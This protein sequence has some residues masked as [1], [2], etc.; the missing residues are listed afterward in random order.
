MLELYQR[1]LHANISFHG[2]LSFLNHWDFFVADPSNQFEQLISTGPH[3][4][5]LEAFAT[6]VKIRTR[7][8]HLLSSA[9]PQSMTTF[10]ASESRRVID[11]ARHF[12]VGFWGLDWQEQSTLEIIPQSIDVGADT[13]TPG[14][15]CLKYGNDGDGLGREYGVKQLQA[16][17]A[18]YLPAIT[19]RL[20][21][22]NPDF[23]LRDSE[24][25]TMQEMC[26]FEHLAKGHS[27]WCD[28]FTPEEWESF[29]YA[30]DVYHYYRAGPGNPSSASMG[31]LWLNATAELLRQGPSAGPLFF[32]L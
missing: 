8:T 14:R 16:F 28:I 19:Q 23:M 18:N 9:S 22:Q 13:L 5:T 6:G 31:M 2:D 4:G 32:S 30:R 24:V 21:Q 25:Y 29:E 26:G 15:S 27:D 10:W 3:A 1:M 20:E 11:T 12:A 7:Y 17:Q